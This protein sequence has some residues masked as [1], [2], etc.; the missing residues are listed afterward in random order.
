MKSLCINIDSDTESWELSQKEFDRVGLTVERFSATVEDN[1]VLAFNKSVY[2]AMEYSVTA[3]PLQDHIGIG[4]FKF[5]GVKRE[6]LLLFE[7]DVVFDTDRFPLNIEKMPP[8]WMTLHFGCNIIGVTGTEWQMPTHFSPG[9]AKL[10]NCWQSH[11][12]LYSAE[13]V[14]F[15]LENFKFVTDEYKTEGCQIFDEWLRVNVLPLGNS[16]LMKP[17]IAYQRPRHSAIWNVETD[18]VGAHKQ[19]NEWLKKNL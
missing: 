10:H 2:R 8:G 7:D 9:L 16:Y 15:I 11:A 14:K 1:R 13:C 5:R 12:T 3:G 19:G 18:Y 17:M 6:H 4:A